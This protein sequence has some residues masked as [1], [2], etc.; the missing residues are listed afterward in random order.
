MLEYLP[1]HE[2]PRD[3]FQQSRVGLFP[4]AD[5]VEFASDLDSKRWRIRQ[6]CLRQL[7][8]SQA[9][10]INIFCAHNTTEYDRCC[11]QAHF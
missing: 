11:E 6:Q 10:E 4:C 1:C 7:N 2:K 5:N 8:R 3:P 9:R